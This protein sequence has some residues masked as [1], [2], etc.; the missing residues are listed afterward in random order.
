LH[1]EAALPAMILGP[2]VEIRG[3]FV[4]EPPGMGK[5]KE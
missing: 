4:G 5:R 1:L 3:F 2:W